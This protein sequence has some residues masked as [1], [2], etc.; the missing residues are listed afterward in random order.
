M[1]EGFYNCST[2]LKYFY[3]HS[4][5]LTIHFSGSFDPAASL[6]NM[7]EEVEDIICTYNW[8]YD[9]FETEF[10]TNDINQETFN[11]SLYGI[12]FTPPECETVCLTFLSNGKMC[13]LFN[14][15]LYGTLSTPQD[16]QYLYSQFVKTQFAGYE[17]HMIIILLF[18]YVEKKYLKDFTVF[19]EGRYW[20]TLNEELLKEKFKQYTSL[21]NSVSASLE[22]NNRKE[23]ESFE[24]Y[25]FRIMMEI[26][27]KRKGQT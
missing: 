20:E 21:L 19:D 2:N 10:D 24:E 11:D 26:D 6:K 13:S 27:A 15:E 3:F 1:I 12:S 18:K 16:Q 5:G 9:I 23:H 7:I 4:M 25:F 22:K 14:L 8:P 17:I